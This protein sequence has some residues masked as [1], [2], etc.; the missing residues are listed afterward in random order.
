[1]GVC[2][3]ISASPLLVNRMD[4]GAETPSIVPLSAGALRG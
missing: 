4:T 3:S 2:P 1:M